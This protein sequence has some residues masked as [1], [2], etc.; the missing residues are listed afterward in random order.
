MNSHGRRRSDSPRSERRVPTHPAE[1]TR[2]GI[3]VRVIKV[4]GRAQGDARLMPAIV[5]ASAQGARVVVVHGGGDEISM[6]QRSMQL[7]PS[8]IDGRRVTSEADLDIVRMVL[9]GTVNKRLV[10]QLSVLGARAVGVSGEDGGLLTAAVGDARLGRVGR[11]IAADVSLLAHLLN[12]GWLPVVSPLAREVGSASGA[13]LNVNGDDAAAAIAA[14]LGADELLFVA[15]VPGVLENGEPLETLDLAAAASLVE[16]GVA[17]GG[18]RAK[19]EAATA[20]LRNG[21]KRVRIAGLDGINDRAAGTAISLPE[22]RDH[23]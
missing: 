12:G 13:G 7:E 18:M 19:L 21:V 8:F 4:G 11:D 17:Q 10:A 2:E 14:G 15:D 5:A 9:S 6:L 20:A 3:T 1:G 22:R 23:A 16:R